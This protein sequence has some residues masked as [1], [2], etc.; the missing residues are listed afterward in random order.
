MERLENE[1]NL[2]RNGITIEGIVE[3]QVVLFENKT[4]RIFDI[5]KVTMPMEKIMIQGLEE[6]TKKG[7]RRNRILISRYVDLLEFWH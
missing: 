3:S 4:K 6:D 1:R 2:E 5:T 7:F